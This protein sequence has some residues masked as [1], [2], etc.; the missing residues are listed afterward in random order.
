MVK[1]V[2]RKV[3]KSQSSPNLFL[4]PFFLFNHVFS[5]KDSRKQRYESKQTR[6]HLSL[7][8]VFQSHWS[9]AFHIA[10]SCWIM[11]GV[12]LSL[13]RIPLFTCTPFLFSQ[14]ELYVL[15]NTTIS[16]P[17]VRI[18]QAT[19]HN[20]YTSLVRHWPHCIYFCHYQ[21]IKYGLY[22]NQLYISSA[23][24]TLSPGRFQE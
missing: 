5:Y 24:Y 22:Q 23:M 18:Q 17:P 12:Y 10:L 1:C 2:I 9:C 20:L 19:T 16:V 6:N 3:K 21:T 11:C 7:F 14:G 8:S 15:H 13:T 4:L